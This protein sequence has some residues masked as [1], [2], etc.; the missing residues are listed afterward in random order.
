[1]SAL[2]LALGLPL[3]PKSSRFAPGSAFSDSVATT[4]P[5]HM[6][7]PFLFARRVAPQKKNG[8]HNEQRNL[9]QQKTTLKGR[10][11]R[12][13]VRDEVKKSRC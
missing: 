8:R 2:C 5:S 7:E 12:V 4:T 11:S 10:K 6:Q 13:D 9:P 1:M 3:L